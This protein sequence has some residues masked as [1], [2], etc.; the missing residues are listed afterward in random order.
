[1]TPRDLLVRPDGAGW[2]ASFAD[3]RWSCAVGRGGLT[4]KKHEG[5]GA[6]PIGRW[7][8][9]RVWYRAD[10]LRAPSGLFGAEAL[11]ENDGWCDDPN[12]P[13]YNRQ[14]VL[15]YGGRHEVLWREDAIYDVIVV[16]GYNDDPPVAGKGSAIFLHIARPDYSG[17]EGCVALAEP[18]LRAF[19]ATCD[20]GSAVVVETS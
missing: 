1:M 4:D 12:D 14:V 15:P 8:L 10:R 5:D 16:L 9:R 13:H 17:T 2:L 20:Q 6:T 18:H 11:A 7:P 19:L 3:S